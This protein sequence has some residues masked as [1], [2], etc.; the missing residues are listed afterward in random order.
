MPALVSMAR[1]GET[2]VT[3]DPLHGLWLHLPP[4]ARGSGPLDEEAAARAVV[5]HGFVPIERE[6]ATWA[7]LDDFRQARAAEAVP[8][9]VVDRDQLTADD[10]A[11]M[12]RV[13]GTWIAR[14]EGH[15]AR[16]LAFELL[17]VPVVRAD[18][19]L[20]D[21]VISMLQELT[22][23]TVAPLLQRPPSDPLTPEAVRRLRQPA[24]A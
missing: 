22:G 23:G 17:R 9:V 18:P 8:D 7:E 5:D 15:R 24:A 21:Q 10:I 16:R 12:L 1:S 19:D 6:F 2:F 4:G 3:R 20:Y 13:A 14:E 11:G